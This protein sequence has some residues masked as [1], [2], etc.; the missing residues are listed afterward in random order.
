MKFGL[1][2]I[3][4]IIF[5]KKISFSYKDIGTGLSSLLP[6]VIN[7]VLLKN[8]T[9][10]VQ[11]PERSLHPSFQIELMDLFCET[12]KTNNNQYLIET[13][14][15]LLV[16]RLMQLIRDKKISNDDVSINYVSKDKDGAKIHNLKMDKNGDFIDKW[17]EG[18][19]DERIKLSLL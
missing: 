8:R 2:I 7:S 18:F 10:G 9:L 17:P 19:F 6:I 15:E 14:S 11:E 1:L 4:G 13:H 5:K 3:V 16:L 12:L